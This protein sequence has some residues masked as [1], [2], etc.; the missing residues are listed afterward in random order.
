MQGVWESADHEVKYLSPGD[1]IEFLFPVGIDYSFADI[2]LTARGEII[3]A[4]PDNEATPVEPDDDAPVDPDIP[5]CSADHPD[6]F[7]ICTGDTGRLWNSAPSNIPIDSYYGVL[8]IWFV[9]DWGSSI[10]N[11]S[12]MVARVTDSVS[13]S[14]VVVGF[15]PGILKLKGATAAQ[16]TSGT[17]GSASTAAWHHAVFSWDTLNN[18]L[19]CFVDGVQVTSA[20]DLGKKMISPGVVNYSQ[21]AQ[22]G[23]AA[24]NNLNYPTNTYNHAPYSDVFLGIPSAFFDLTVPANLAMFYA[25]GP[26]DHSG[27]PSTPIGATPFIYLHGSQADYHINHGNGGDMVELDTANVLNFG[28]SPW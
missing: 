14:E 16:P 1:R 6:Q 26:V 21:I 12:F 5:T 3:C 25:G 24:V 11:T 4:V 15:G 28:S 10:G 22:F 2:A 27:D 18:V 19:Q 13:G 8:S 17:F 23:V 20:A 9:D 7:V